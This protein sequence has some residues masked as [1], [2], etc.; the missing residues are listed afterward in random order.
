MVMRVAESGK[1][2]IVFI[3]MCGGLIAYHSC[4]DR[5]VIIGRML[6]VRSRV[7]LLRI[8]ADRNER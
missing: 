2:H 7:E 5:R 4:D 8:E 1:L 3:K 6:L